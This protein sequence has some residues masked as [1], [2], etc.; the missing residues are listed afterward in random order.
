MDK[1]VDRISVLAEESVPACLLFPVMLFLVVLVS[2]LGPR[3]VTYDEIQKVGM[4]R[5]S[6]D[7]TTLPLFLSCNN[8]NSLAM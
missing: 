2:L 1:L 6:L 4:L 8:I 5:R 7:E 3:R